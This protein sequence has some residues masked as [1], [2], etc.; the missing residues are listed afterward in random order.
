MY[1]LLKFHNFDTLT[2]MSQQSKMFPFKN[3][4]IEKKPCNSTGK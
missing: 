4:L 2:L 3:A 1:V